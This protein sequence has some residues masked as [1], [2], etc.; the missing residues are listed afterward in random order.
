MFAHDLWHS[1]IE[2][3]SNS[4]DLNT[5]DRAKPPARRGCTPT[6]RRAKPQ[7]FNL[8]GIVKS[9]F[10]DWIPAFAGMTPVVSI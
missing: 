8:D 1:Q 6:P 3:L 9:R 4:I 5:K 7:I 2:Y 10:K